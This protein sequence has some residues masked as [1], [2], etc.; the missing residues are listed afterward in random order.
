MAISH[1]PRPRRAVTRLFPSLFSGAS[2]LATYE[3]LYAVA[4]R[5][6]A[7]LVIHFEHPVRTNVVWLDTS[8]R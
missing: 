7:S 5:P 8:S 6:A 1:P 4:R 2:L 3:T